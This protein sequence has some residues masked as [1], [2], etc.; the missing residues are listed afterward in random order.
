MGAGPSSVCP[1]LSDGVP[2]VLATRRAEPILADEESSLADE[3]SSLAAPPL[4]Y[5]P[6]PLPR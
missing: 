4:A 5:R 1:S 3:E 6:N 2:L